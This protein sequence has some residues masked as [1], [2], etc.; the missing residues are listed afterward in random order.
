MNA[1]LAINMYTAKSDGL[2]VKQYLPEEN[3]IVLTNDRKI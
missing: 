3:A 1:S 2:G